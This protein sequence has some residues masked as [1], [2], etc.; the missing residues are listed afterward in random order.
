M[1]NKDYQKMIIRISWLLMLGYIL[2]IGIN[3]TK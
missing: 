1:E 3:G 2:Y